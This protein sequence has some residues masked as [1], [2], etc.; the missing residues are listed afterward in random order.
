M[1]ASY[2]RRRYMRRGAPEGAIVRPIAA[3]EYTARVCRPY[4]AYRAG[5][6]RIIGIG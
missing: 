4:G 3:S 6:A 2:V 5:G 1:A